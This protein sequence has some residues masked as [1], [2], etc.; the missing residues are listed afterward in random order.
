MASEYIT[1][2][3]PEAEMERV[4]DRQAMIRRLRRFIPKGSDAR[5][6]EVGEDF[7]PWRNEPDLVDRVINRVDRNGLGPKL[8]VQRKEDLESLSIREVSA[9][10]DL[11]AHPGV[12]AMHAEVF[13][14]FAVR[15]GGLFLCRFIDGTRTVS[16]HGFVDD[17]WK[18]AAEDVFVTEGGM[19]DL[20]KVSLFV[21]EGM[22]SG[23][24]PGGL[25]V[26]VDQSIF[27]APD[28]RERVYGGRQ[29]FHGHYG[30]SGGH[31]CSP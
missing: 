7:G 25:E 27:T 15:S 9:V 16:H 30:F 13:E 23:R 1:A 12:E 6:R 3:F 14:K 8:I 11:G 19:A 26:I 17:D 28:F 18:G 5:L 21:V 22:R 24:F 10:P 20:V 2:R 4:Q 31:A 29:H